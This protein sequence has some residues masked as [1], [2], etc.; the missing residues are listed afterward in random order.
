M[1]AYKH[2]RIK[3]KK[4]KQAQ[5]LTYLPV[6]NFRS[7]MAFHYLDGINV[8]LGDM[9]HLILLLGSKKLLE[10]TGEGLSAPGA[11]QRL[12]IRVSGMVPTPEQLD[13]T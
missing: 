8:L 7:D 3:K 12:V 13:T 4:Q 6:Q 10:H 11:S 5:A 2:K 1:V 9:E